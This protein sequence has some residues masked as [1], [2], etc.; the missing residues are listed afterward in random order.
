VRP[1]VISARAP[2]M[3]LD[4]TGAGF[5]V[6]PTVGRA[7]VALG[8]GGLPRGRSVIFTARTLR[9]DHLTLHAIAMRRKRVVVVVFIDR[10]SALD[11]D[12][13]RRLA[14]ISSICS[15]P[16]DCCEQALENLRHAVRTARLDLIVVDSVAALT[17]RGPRSTREWETPPWLSGAA[18]S[19]RCAAHPP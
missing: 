8:C 13:A 6:I 11:T 5:E 15:G 12:S 10:G 9:Q 3:R 14:S 4:C 16:P 18:A 17:P 7:D 19:Q 1:Q 2:V